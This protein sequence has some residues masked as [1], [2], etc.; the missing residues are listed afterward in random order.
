MITIPSKLILDDDS[1]DYSLDGNTLKLDESDKGT[2]NDLFKLMVKFLVSP[3]AKGDYLNIERNLRHY[4]D[5]DFLNNAEEQM[6]EMEWSRDEYD[7]YVKDAYNTLMQMDIE[8]L[9]QEQ[10]MRKLRFKRHEDSFDQEDLQRVLRNV[11]DIDVKVSGYLNTR[12]FNSIIGVSRTSSAGSKLR[13][14]AQSAQGASRKRRAVY[15]DATEKLHEYTE[16][17]VIKSKEVGGGDYNNTPA[18]D[19]VYELTIDTE[20]MFN[21][22]FD[23]AGINPKKD[24]ISKA[25]VTLES[26]K[27]DFSDNPDNINITPTYPELS[28]LKKEL[29]LPWLPSDLEEEANKDSKIEEYL[30]EINLKLL[31]NDI[32]EDVATTQYDLLDSREEEIIL[33]CFNANII[34]RKQLND[35][36]TERNTIGK[37]RLSNKEER[38]IKKY[39]DDKR[40]GDDKKPFTNEL[41]QKIYSE[42]VEPKSESVMDIVIHADDASSKGD[43]KLFDE[44]IG[45]I[46][47]VSKTGFKDISEKNKTL[48]DNYEAMLDPRN[49]GL[50]RW[51]IK[52]RKVPEAS[53]KALEITLDR[54]TMASGISSEEHKRNHKTLL[55]E[56][57][58]VYKLNTTKYKGRKV[59]FVEYFEHQPTS[60]NSEMGSK[61]KISGYSRPTK[62]GRSRELEGGAISDVSITGRTFHSS[63]K[64]QLRKL[65][66]YI[67]G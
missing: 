37:K 60:Y 7:G 54:P 45:E 62:D 16:I 39:V 34:S 25:E 55:D 46:P 21:D 1:N 15:N 6:T 27:E 53:V 38:F 64:R 56:K 58:N 17:K 4:F 10:I 63:I 49:I 50:H 52:V 22:I 40:R 28:D 24:K 23:A 14:V 3:S 33:N 12:T 9:L 29:E 47:N 2:S 26:L 44:P 19:I 67:N 43:I 36:L 59:F 35:Y 13:S 18:M 48:K 8:E 51:E 41:E 65:E 31:W 11:K 57:W 32:Y 20:K 5:Y 66:R 42:L 30:I 61:P